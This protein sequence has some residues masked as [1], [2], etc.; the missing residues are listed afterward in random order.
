MISPAKGRV[1]FWPSADLLHEFYFSFNLFWGWNFWGSNNCRPDRERTIVIPYPLLFSFFPPSRSCLQHNHEKV[2]L[3][4]QVLIRSLSSMSW[5]FF[6][7]T[8]FRKSKEFPKDII[9]N[10]DQWKVSRKETKG[11]VVVYNKGS[12]FIVGWSLRNYTE[13]EKIHY[14]YYSSVH[15]GMTYKLD[16]IKENMFFH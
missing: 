10:I 2:V 4:L 11:S 13:F 1:Y 14:C 15:P 12:F 6:S 7:F 3:H 8:S 9:C 5:P 16:K